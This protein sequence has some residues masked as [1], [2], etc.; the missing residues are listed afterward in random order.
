MLAILGAMEEEVAL[1]RGEMQVTQESVHAGINVIRGDFKGTPIAL[2]QCGIGKVNAT[3]CTQMLVDL[4]QPEGMIFSGVAGGL[5][6]NM[7]V[8]DIVVASH[9]IQF[10]IDLTAFGR[11]HGEL[12]DSDRMIQSDANMVSQTADC[13]DAVFEGEADAPNLMI[14]TV[15]SGDKFIEDSET[16]R[17]LQREFGALATEMEGAAVG[18]TCQLNEVPF[19]IIRGLSDTANESAPDDFKSNLHTVCKHSFR[20]MERLI[21]TAGESL[22]AAEASAP[23]QVAASA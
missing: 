18:Y 7:Q 17:W 2:A 10:D 5:L 1:L 19:I 3:I 6:P 15:V 16:L 8:G 21:P 20:L 22:S 13:F 9:L 23:Q 12:P 4:Y 11:R 14:G